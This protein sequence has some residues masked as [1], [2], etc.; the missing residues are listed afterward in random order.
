M[1]MFL[2][3]KKYIKWTVNISK[4][5]PT[6][7]KLFLFT[8]DMPQKW[9]LSSSVKCIFRETRANR[10]LVKQCIVFI[11]DCDAE[12]NQKMRIVNIERN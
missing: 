7:R 8:M 1:H 11:A 3:T 9:N 2:M 12:C 5:A 6:I 4:V 10:I